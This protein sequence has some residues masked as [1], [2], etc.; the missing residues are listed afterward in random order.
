MILSGRVDQPS[1]VHEKAVRWPA[2]AAAS[3]LMVVTTPVMGQDVFNDAG[4][5]GVF[6]NIANWAGP[7]PVGFPTDFEGNWIGIDVGALLDINVS[8]DVTNIGGLINQGLGSIVNFSGTGSFSFNNTN[9]GAPFGEIN[10]GDGSILFDIEM[11]SLT[12]MTFDLT[13]GGLLSFGEKSTFADVVTINSAVNSALVVADGDLEFGGL[14]TVN[15][16]LDIDMEGGVMSFLQGGTFSDIVNI[17]M[18]GGIGSGTINFGGST[19]FAETVNIT[20]NGG[21]INSD[22]GSLVFEGDVTST[23]GGS[24]AS[25]GEGTITFQRIFDATG[26][27]TFIMSSSGALNFDGQVNLD[28]GTITF[29]GSGGSLDGYSMFFNDE[30]SLTSGT[31]FAAID[32]AN[33]FFND[34]FDFEDT[35]LFSGSN[36]GTFVFSDIV[37]SLVLDGTNNFHSD[38]AVVEFDRNVEFTGGEGLLATNSGEFRFNTDIVASSGSIFSADDLG[39]FRFNQSFTGNGEQ[40]F[41]TSLAGNA[42]GSFFFVGELRLQNDDAIAA[43]TFRTASVL[44]DSLSIDDAYN[45]ILD[46]TDGKSGIQTSNGLI[47][48]GSHE[49]LFTGETEMGF[50][51]A[52]SLAAGG[53]LDMVND[54]GTASVA[55]N[56]D[57]DIAGDYDFLFAGG[58]DAENDTL[59]FSLG[60]ES[61]TITVGGDLFFGDSAGGDLNAAVNIDIN[62]ALVLAEELE[63]LN[64]TIDLSNAGDAVSTLSF[65]NE[66]LADVSDGVLDIVSGTVNFFGGK[67]TGTE[68]VMDLMIGN[69]GIVRLQPIPNPGQ[70]SSLSKE[71]FFKELN[72]TVDGGVVMA[73]K[74]PD[75]EN[76]SVTL[77]VGGGDYSGVLTD[78]ADEETS[79][80]LLFNV[81]GGTFIYK[82]QA[83]YTGATQLRDG[84]VIQIG[85]EEGGRGEIIG[86]TRLGMFATLPGDANNQLVIKNGQFTTGTGEESFQDGKVLMQDNSLVR[87]ENPDG[88]DV[89]G[90]TIA[91]DLDMVASSAT[92]EMEAGTRVQILGDSDIFGNFSIF[93]IGN[94][95]PDEFD[96]I[97]GDDAE[98]SLIMSGVMDFSGDSR[99][100]F[101]GSN[102]IAQG[103]QLLLSENAFLESSL[104]LHVTGVNAL[105]EAS[106]DS[107]LTLGTGVDT[108]RSL[109]VD[110]GIFRVKDDASVTAQQL[111]EVG[112]GKLVLEDNGLLVAESGLSLGPVGGLLMSGNSL[113]DVTSGITVS[114]QGSDISGSSTI[115]TDGLTILDGGK[116]TFDFDEDANAPTVTMQGNDLVIE[117]GGALVGNAN[118]N[119]LG[120]MLVSGRLRAGAEGEAS[121]R[122]ILEDGN[123]VIEDGGQLELGFNWD[124][125][126]LV[127]SNSFVE[128]LAGDIIFADGSSFTLNVEN[129]AYIPTDR[130]YTLLR[131]DNF[132]DLPTPQASAV[133]VTRRWHEADS[134]PTEYVVTRSA[135]YLGY[136]DPT[137]PNNNTQCLSGDL[138]EV[139]LW[140]N[141]LIPLADANPNGPAGNL[142]G[143]FDAIETCAAYDAAV[144]G[145][146]PTTQGSVIQMA[147]KTQ[148]FEVL[149]D[150]IRREAISAGVS[151]PAPFRLEGTDPTKLL[152]QADDAYIASQVRKSGRP[153]TEMMVFGRGYGR[154]LA[155]PTKGNVIGFDGNEYGGFGGFGYDI[156]KGLVVGVNMGYSAFSG[157]LEGGYGN[158]RVGTLR[159]GPFIS[160]ADDDGW[161][162][163][164]ALGAGWNRF[165]YTRVNPTL[166]GS[167]SVDGETNGF[168]IDFSVGGGYSIDLAESFVLTPEAS[169]LYSYL[170]TA[171]INETVNQPGSLPLNINPGDLN[172]FVGRVGANLA[173]VA[174]PGLVFD[175]EG[176]WQGNFT[177]S[178][179]YGANPIGLTGAIPVLPID[180]TN[181]N[182][183]YLGGGVSWLIDWSVAV[184]VRYSGRFG[185]GVTS[186]MVYGGVSVRF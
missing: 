154:S 160:Y 58:T 1:L 2:L 132:V 94:T 46:G 52:S 100:K 162:I 30:V 109:F 12:A 158:E 96:L 128:A 111:V 65:R 9:V 165:T 64:I 62:G 136:A 21:I 48:E 61:S 78:G 60:N 72:S 124:T 16:P 31:G 156:A 45:L 143:S 131:A 23:A 145:I 103:G 110:D 174:L 144:I 81:N 166:P 4:G 147:S 10:T 134:A 5:D 97:L 85:D 183:A 18:G 63:S 138:A 139:G 164:A 112:F 71:F 68:G 185:D 44:A 69:D 11:E 107:R 3:L 176:G 17:D 74:N 66:A 7:L 87:I 59:D 170:N 70:P 99:S 182:T 47:A 118:F 34:Q 15:G 36:G 67:T 54:L 140:L 49:F 104:E 42:G 116:L 77:E 73:Y 14:V 181:F 57:V 163:E 150:E 179:D 130:E 108:E 79:T 173:F 22:G 178:E 35:V 51:G 135:N 186:N 151:S 113:V 146:Q 37:D 98:D 175:L 24:F 91:G 115:I 127:G 55:F 86:S 84:G 137:D 106:G 126:D 184:N 13:G 26:D 90:M 25:S 114:G 153:H 29:G 180:S 125:V 19:T 75:E 102:E 88:A 83:D 117:S 8:T 155:L 105:V 121:G 148:Y 76:L 142:L 172:S 80:S 95:G 6:E 50:G 82:G 41:G 119:G 171:D 56:G 32:G 161:F 159:G 129:N 122:L 123:L 38:G 141:T 93:G 20:N 120:N 168:Q 39:I 92:F 133:S 169:F 33:V 167:G 101:F 89:S 149:R 177:L 53:T 157:N 27:Q 28:G 152:M 43:A 40:F